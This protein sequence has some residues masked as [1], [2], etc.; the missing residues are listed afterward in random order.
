M[1]S[2]WEGADGLGDVGLL[3]LVSG[4]VRLFWT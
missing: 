2:A 3:S 1:F 4:H